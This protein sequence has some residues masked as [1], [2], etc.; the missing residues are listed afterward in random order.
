MKCICW[1]MKIN[2]DFILFLIVEKRKVDDVDDPEP[3]TSTGLP[4]KMQSNYMH[5]LTWLYIIV[6]SCVCLY[7][8]LLFVILYLLMVVL[9]K[10]VTCRYCSAFKPVYLND[11]GIFP[12]CRQSRVCSKC[13]CRRQAHYYTS[14]D[15]EICY[16]C[17]LPPSNTLSSVQNL[18]QDQPLH[19]DPTILDVDMLIRSLQSTIAHNMDRHF[20]EQ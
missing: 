12:K 4:I 15:A 11:Q 16:F 19:I 2:I 17:L 6:Y 10:D 5:H 8:H 14:K 13:K 20:T 1:E 3:S 9:E 7:A 18:F